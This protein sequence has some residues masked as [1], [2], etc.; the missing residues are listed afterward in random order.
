[1]NLGL[2]LTRK[3]FVEKLI[4]EIVVLTEILKWYRI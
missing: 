3:G 4:F 1:M 2:R